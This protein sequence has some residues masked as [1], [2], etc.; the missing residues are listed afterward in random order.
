[1][2]T[3][4]AATPAFISDRRETGPAP[5]PSISSGFDIDM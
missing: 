1:V 3:A 2:A 4:N 5:V